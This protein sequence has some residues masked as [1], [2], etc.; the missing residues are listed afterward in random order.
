MLGVSIFAGLLMGPDDTVQEV[1]STT[2]VQVDSVDLILT[3]SLC[4]PTLNFMVCADA[5]EVPEGVKVLATLV[6]FSS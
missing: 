4:L 3:N 5:P 2:P 6:H 1:G